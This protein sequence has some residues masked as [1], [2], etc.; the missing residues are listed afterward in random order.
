MQVKEI[1]IIDVNYIYEFI[2]EREYKTTTKFIMNV[3]PSI[4]R[5][6][7][8]INSMIYDLKVTNHK[9]VELTIVDN[10]KPKR[11]YQS[12]DINEK[13]KIQRG[14]GVAETQL[15]SIT[16]LLLSSDQL[17]ERGYENF[18]INISYT[19]F[20]NSQ[21]RGFF[22]DSIE[23]KEFLI[24]NGF[25]LIAEIKIP[26]HYNIDVKNLKMNWLESEHVNNKNIP[27]KFI[28]KDSKYVIIESPQN[29]EKTDFTVLIWKIIIYKINL[30][31]MRFGFYC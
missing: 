30:N 17:S 26:Q 12:N 14:N 2:S 18:E 23:Y 25:N 21:F 13:I 15:R 9:G 19:L 24:G 11:K 5:Y 6:N 1:D 20:N 27:F 7:H 31:W 4:D 22:K 29:S 8:S 10:A 3:P 16:I 28:L